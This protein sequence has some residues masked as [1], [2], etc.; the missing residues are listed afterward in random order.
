MEH[1]YKYII[2]KK[3]IKIQRN[4]FYPGLIVLQSE[5]DYQTQNCNFLVNETYVGTIF[6]LEFKGFDGHF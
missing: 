3:K 4:R 1:D 6:F 5:K 2:I